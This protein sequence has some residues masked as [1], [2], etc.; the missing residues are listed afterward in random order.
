M[1]DKKSETAQLE[2]LMAKILRFGI[3]LSV[4]LMLLGLGLYLIQNK[5]FEEIKSLTT[6]HVMD[7]VLGHSLFDG[8]TLMLFGV[9]VLILTP[10]FRVISTFLAFIHQKDRLYIGFTGLVIVIIILSII[11][12]F[13]VEP[14]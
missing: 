1:T 6:F 9:F 12:G 10:I 3:L 4:F 2:V 8:V 11:M 14:K 7:Y 5:T 13:W